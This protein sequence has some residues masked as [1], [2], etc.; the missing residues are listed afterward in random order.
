[1][2]LISARKDFWDSNLLSDSDEI[3]NVVLTD[4]SL[5]D[6]VSEAKFLADIT[7]KRILLIIHGYNNEEDDVVRAYDIIENKINSLLSDAGGEPVY[8]TII[9]YTWP[10]GDDGLDYFAA[11]KR[12]GAVAPRVDTWLSKMVNVADSIDVMAHSMG[13]RIALMAQ[14]NGKGKRIRN[15]FTM[16]AA[17]DDE[18]IEMGQEYYVSTQNCDTSYVFHSSLDSVLANAYKLAEGDRALGQYGPEDTASIIDNSKNVKVIN[19]KNVV[20]KHGGYKQCDSL[21]RYI[22][23]EFGLGKANQFTTLS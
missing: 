21:Y 3:R 14:K 8:D 4:E 12:S 18:S 7:N 13:C 5:G 19:C 16:A 1:M 22:A 10:G 11:R 17:V 6:P 23:N 2:L 15:L 20:K 9:G